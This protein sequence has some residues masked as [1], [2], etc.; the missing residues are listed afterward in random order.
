MWASINGSCGWS[1]KRWHEG[2]EWSNI[3]RQTQ[4]TLAWRALRRAAEQED[5]RQ[6]ANS[7]FRRA[8]ECD[9][10]EPRIRS[11]VRRTS[12]IGEKSLELDLAC[13]ATLYPRG[14]RWQ[15]AAGYRALLQYDAVSIFSADC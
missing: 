13:L 4:P 9:P 15:Q 3:A 8:F 5:N 1:L 11:S 7:I 10:Y 6:E 12:L 2:A 14:Q